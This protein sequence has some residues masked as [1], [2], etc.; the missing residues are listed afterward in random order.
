MRQSGERRL[1]RPMTLVVGVAF[2][3]ALVPASAMT[4]AQASAG[5]SQAAPS[6]ATAAALLARHKAPTQ[7]HGFSTAAATVTL[8]GAVQD[9]VVISPRA[10]RTVL[11]QARR[12]G[13]SHF[14]TQSASSSSARGKFRAV[15]RPTSGG[16]WRYRLVVKPTPKRAGV[17]SAARLVTVANPADHTAPHAVQGL[18]VSEVTLDSATLSWANPGDADFTGVTIRRAVGATAPGT[19]SSGTP[20]ADTGRT[21]TS[22]KDSG[23]ADN[24]TYSYALFAHDASSNYGPVASLTLRTT[25][26]AVT[27]LHATAV[28]R[29]SVALAWTD[30]ADPDFTGVTIQRQD[31]ST[32]PVSA[33]DGANVADVASPDSVVTDTTVQG[34]HTYTYAAF[35]HDAAGHA[36]AA[37]TVTVTTRSN[38]TIAQ[39][40][41]NPL[42]SVHTDERVTSGTAV[43]FDGSES[44]PAVGA[45]HF[46]SWEI[47]YGDSTSDSFNG[48]LSAVDVLNTTHTYTGTGDK[49]ATLTVTDS[50][51]GTASTTL[52]VHVLAAPEVSLSLKTSNPQANL[53][54]TFEITPNIP[55]GETITSYQAVVTGDE[56]FFLNGTSAPPPTM[57]LTFKPGSY[58][59]VFTLKTD[60]GGYVASA[61]VVVEVP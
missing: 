5:V 15:Y 6:N 28:N 16:D 53:P 52:L 24:T 43:A 48:P 17:T 47:D 41:V 56:V 20:V 38:G 12:P 49:T 22:F 13:S 37:A 1:R 32:P 11:V 2:C 26:T 23:L 58:Q 21:V 60:G 45:D 9:Q 29:T 30:P 31:G 54:M 57:D 14:V 35:A 36:S 46:V 42:P 33:T 44:L 40:D 34:S 50:G 19:P 18:K 4:A 7:I 10:R 51:G 39:L 55:Q 8:G 61:P 3:A 59:V 27:G 25:R